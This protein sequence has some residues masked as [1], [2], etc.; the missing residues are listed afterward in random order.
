MPLPAPSTGA[1]IFRASKGESPSSTVHG[2]VDLKRDRRRGQGR[3]ERLA[4]RS[5]SLA[6][7]VGALAMSDH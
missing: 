3:S 7:S 4:V 5:T 2:H 1:R 6:S